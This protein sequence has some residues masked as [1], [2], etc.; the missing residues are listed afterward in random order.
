MKVSFSNI[1]S[2]KAGI[3][4]YLLSFKCLADCAKVFVK[5][6]SCYIK[7]K[8]ESFKFVYVFLLF[9]ARN[10]HIFNTTNHS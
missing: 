3:I 9:M 5:S 1:I 6:V 4:Y 7:L 2:Q 8:K 10:L